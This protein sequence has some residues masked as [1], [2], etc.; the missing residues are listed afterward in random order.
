[1]IPPRR[2]SVSSALA[3]ACLAILVA[4]SFPVALLLLG[5][6]FVLL[7]HGIAAVFRHF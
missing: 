6:P 2:R 1:M 4:L 5:A 7:G 3:D